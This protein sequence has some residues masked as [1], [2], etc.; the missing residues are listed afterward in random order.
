[1]HSSLMFQILTFFNLIFLAMFYVAEICMYIFKGISFLYPPSYMICD[2][3]IFGCALL[4]ELIRLKLARAGNLTERRLPILGTIC[5]TIPATLASIYLLL[6]QTYILRIELIL[7]SINIVFHGLE[8]LYC[9][10]LA[11]GFTT[12]SELK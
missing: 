6:W 4:L 10:I 3:L 2:L 11:I 1:M 8:I 12:S 5:L 7:S 9:T